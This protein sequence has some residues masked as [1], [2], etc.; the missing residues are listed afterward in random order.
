[1]RRFVSLLILF[2]S[3]VFAAAL[4]AA[5][6]EPGSGEDTALWSLIDTNLRGA[7]EAYH[8]GRNTE[9]YKLAVSAYLDGF[10][11]IE[12][13]LDLVDHDL[14]KSIESAMA[15]LR[16][17]IRQSAPVA[18]VDRQYDVVRQLLSQA[19]QKMHQGTGIAPGLAAT[20]SGAI[21]LREGTEA[22]LVIASL[23]AF[24]RK[25]GRGHAVAYIHAGWIAALLLGVA[26]WWIA[27]AV[28]EISGAGREAT[29]GVVALLAA[30][31]LIYVG[32]WLH[33]T[34]HAK[35]WKGYLHDKVGGALS[36]GQLWVLVLISFTAAYREVFETVLFYQALI[37]EAGPGSGPYL[38]GGAAAGLALLVIVSLLIFHFSVRLPM[39]LFFN[40]NA[41][42]LVMLS[43]VIAGKG[44]AALQEAGYVPLNRV[45][46]PEWN[47]V[48]LYANWESLGVQ[49]SMLVLVVLLLSLSRSRAQRNL[50]S[51]AA[52]T[53]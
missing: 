15:E 38:L 12:T 33:D 41:V 14:M 30:G 16:L 40:V 39:R 7:S 49:A 37:L 50:T 25:T 5:E 32:Y 51:P 34:M 31:M 43:L 45:A 17:L 26:T 2:C 21:L 42:I 22:A 4:P 9:A 53:D 18:E 46:F 36:I 11:L 24:L 8:A 23:I 48:G 28:I 27:S 10:E 13:R 44:I 29:E 1:M 3:A 35:R 52:G 47:A 6:V 20:S 19:Q